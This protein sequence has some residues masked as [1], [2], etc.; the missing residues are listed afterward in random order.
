[1]MTTPLSTAGLVKNLALMAYIS[2][3]SDA[4]PV[5]RA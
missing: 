4:A 2:K 5:L 3:G 1:M